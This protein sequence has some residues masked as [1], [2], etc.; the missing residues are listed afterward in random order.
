M[1]VVSSHEISL[2]NI[3]SA[4]NTYELVAENTNEEQTSQRRR[5]PTSKTSNQLT[6]LDRFPS[7]PK[8]AESPSPWQIEDSDT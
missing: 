7:S 8:A 2:Q 1:F 4:R 3:D 5:S 6:I